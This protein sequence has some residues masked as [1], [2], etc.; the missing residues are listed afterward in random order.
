M[1]EYRVELLDHGDDPTAYSYSRRASLRC[2]EVKS[3]RLMEVPT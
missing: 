2:A 3:Q 1:N